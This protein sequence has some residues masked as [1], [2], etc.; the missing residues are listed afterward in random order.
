MKRIVLESINSTNDHAE[1]IADKTHENILII[2]KSQTNGRGQF[3]RKWFSEPNKSITL[4][5]LLKNKSGDKKL[6]KDA[7]EHIPVIISKKLNELYGVNSKVVLPNDI[8]INN[9]KVCGILIEA[10]FKAD[11]L[12]YV[13]VGVGINLNNDDF[14]DDIKS[15]ATSIKLEI[16]KDSDADILTDKLEEAI[17]EL[18]D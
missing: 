7:L 17:E 18:Y 11:T 16:K 10:H 5:F 8:K 2:A 9:K 1:K 12:E 15:I 6:R 13:V 4:S 3:D 14:P